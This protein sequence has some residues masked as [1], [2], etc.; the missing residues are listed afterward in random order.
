M[1][2]LLEVLVQFWNSRLAHVF[3][4]TRKRKLNILYSAIKEMCSNVNGQ[5]LFG[6]CC[7]LPL[8]TST[9]IY[10]SFKQNKQLE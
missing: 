10:K 9:Y 5:H 3:R 4:Q 8:A 6:A 1:F 2:V 7:L